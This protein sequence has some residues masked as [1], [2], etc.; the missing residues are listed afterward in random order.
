MKK[1]A[2]LFFER[3]FPFFF[4]SLLA[5]CMPAMYAA[6]FIPTAI[7]GG[8]IAYHYLP[9]ES[10]VEL[11]KPNGNGALD[12][13][14]MQGIKSVITQNEYALVY[15]R[16]NQDSLFK[17]VKASKTIPLNSIIAAKEA[18]K[19]GVDAFVM[20]DATG[21]NYEVGFLSS[22]RIFGSAT[23]TIVTSGG[24][25]VYKQTATLK[26]KMSSTEGLSERQIWETLARVLV[27]DMKLSIS[28]TTP[29]KEKSRLGSL[30]SW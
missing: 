27:D 16:E 20:I 8:A 10:E 11:S 2:R 21:E 6:Q 4:L 1:L 30:V 13:R 24:K 17:T 28:S 29:P 23:V 22:T 18:K 12:R 5:G 3:V 25:V 26:Q 19:N 7:A 9:G 15:L 14:E